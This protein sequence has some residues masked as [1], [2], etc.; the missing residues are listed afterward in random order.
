MPLKKETIG[1]LTPKYS[2]ILNE[3]SDYRVSKCPKCDFNTFK[4]KFP[5]LIY[6]S[7]SIPI[8][9]GLSCTY[10]AKCELIIAHQHELE[11]ELYE[12]FNKINPGVIGN[13]YFVVG[14]MN[15]NVWKKNIGKKSNFTQILEHIADFKEV[16]DLHYQPAGWYHS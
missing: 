12:I 11:G 6:V 7:K 9:L 3:H 15:K 5:L 16:L 2:F 1:Q 14:T 8:T 10:C 4:R 13:E